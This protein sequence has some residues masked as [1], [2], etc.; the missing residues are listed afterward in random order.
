MS[1]IFFTFI[2]AIM[3]E[4]II[5]LT[6]KRN[7]FINFY[8]LKDNKLTP[9]NGGKQSIYQTQQ[10]TSNSL[11]LMVTYLRSLHRGTCLAYSTSQLIYLSY[12]GHKVGQIIVTVARGIYLS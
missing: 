1:D 8:N 7:V 12:I 2:M 3:S 6:A 11:F 5:S 10:T 4:I 9:F